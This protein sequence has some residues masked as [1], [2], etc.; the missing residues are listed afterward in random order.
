MEDIGILNP[1]SE[2]DL[3]Y[4]HYCF[5]E[6]INHKLNEWVDAYIS[7]PLNS[8]HNLT[9]IQLWVQGRFA[10]ASFEQMVSDDYGIDWDASINIGSSCEK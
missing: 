10:N 9:P 2:S 4:L 8:E 5:R 7:H 3:W 6:L 1:L